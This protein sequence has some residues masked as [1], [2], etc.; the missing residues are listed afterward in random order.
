[1]TRKRIHFMGIGGIGQ[2]GIARI[3]NAQG[4]QVSGCDRKQTH[5]TQQLESEG[6]RIYIGHDP[7]HCDMADVMVYTAAVPID[8]PEL[9]A[10]RQQGL[11]VIRRSEALARVMTERRGLAITGAHGKTTTTTMVTSILEAAGM[12]PQA[13]I[14]GEVARYGGNVRLGQGK[15]VVAEA[16]EAYSSF[17]DLHPY[18]AIVTNADP[19]HLDHYKTP[20]RMW[21]AYKQFLSQVDPNG[22]VVICADDPRCE[23]LSEASRARVV[24]VGRDRGDYRIVLNSTAPVSFRLGRGEVDLGSFDVQ[25]L[26]A[27][28]AVDAGLA[29]VLALELGVSV[30]SIYEGLRHFPGVARRMEWIGSVDDIRIV[31]D[32]AHHP[33]EVA[34]TL[35]ALRATLDGRLVVAF[36]PHLYSRTRDFMAQ[37]AEALSQGPDVLVITEIYP[38]REEP[39]SGIDAAALADAVR[40]AA[41][42]LTVYT[43]P[44]VESTAHVLSQLVNPGDTVLTMGAG[45]LDQA[46]RRLLSILAERAGSV[47]GNDRI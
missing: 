41:P 29:A 40:S 11:E 17:L 6:I 31:D 14:G 21:D 1:M 4:W 28:I 42:Q 26:G 47:R 5:M 37:F 34:V 44:D 25:A 10:A 15:Y 33:A 22:V 43:A 38:A 18:A 24:T 3:L 12:D 32:Y 19:D 23:M 30:N 39:I 46:A 9:E 27:H 36:Q 16:C 8:H 2:S 35:S 45:E 20:E 13:I 7:S